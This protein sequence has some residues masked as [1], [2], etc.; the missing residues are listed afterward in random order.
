MSETIMIYRAQ[1][2]EL[3]ME[4]IRMHERRLGYYDALKKGKIPGN[5]LSEQSAKLVQYYPVLHE[6]IRQGRFDAQL[7]GQSKYHISD[8]LCKCAILSYYYEFN[9][10]SMP[11]LSVM[12]GESFS[13]TIYNTMPE[14]PEDFKNMHAQDQMAYLKREVGEGNHIRRQAAA[15]NLAPELLEDVGTRAKKLRGL[16]PYMEL[17]WLFHLDR[18]F[19]NITLRH[20]MNLSKR[21]KD[22]YTWEEV[23]ALTNEWNEPDSG[24]KELP[25]FGAQYQQQRPRYPGLFY[26]FENRQ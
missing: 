2:G 10:P 5:T 18:P 21:G 17:S 16:L 25:S 11:D 23:N 4:T 12:P 6:I 13:F 9:I 24:W 14:G 3:I 22:D 8:L 26:S 19:M 7:S 20:F 15:G 1:A